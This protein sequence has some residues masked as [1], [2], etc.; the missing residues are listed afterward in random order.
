MLCFLIFGS[1]Y[2]ISEEQKKVDFVKCD[3]GRYLLDTALHARHKTLD[4]ESG[5]VGNILTRCI[6]GAKIMLAQNTLICYTEFRYKFLFCIRCNNCY[7]HI[8]KSILSVTLLRRRQLICHLSDC[9]SAL[10]FSRLFL[11][12]DE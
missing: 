7:L 10:C 9:F 3:S 6:R 1:I 5:C 4:I 11:F 2:C 12:F 8:N